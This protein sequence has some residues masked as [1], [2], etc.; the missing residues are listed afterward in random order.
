MLNAKARVVSC[1]TIHKLRKDKIFSE[2]EKQK[3]ILF[4]GL[5]QKRLG[6]SM[7]QPE[8]PIPDEYEPYCDDSDPDYVQLPEDNDPVDT[9]STTAFENPITYRWINAEMNQPQEEAMKNSK[10]IGLATD[11]YGNV[12]GTYDDN[13]YSNTMVYDVEFLDGYIKEY[14]ENAIS[15]IC[16][17]S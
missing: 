5:I 15:E 13:P 3:R 2:T 9:D 11:Q 8:K 16:M 6:D 10:V 14:S 4:G 17:P 7:A 1:C 12:I